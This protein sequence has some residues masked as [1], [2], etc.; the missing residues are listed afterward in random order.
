MF[1]PGSG[2]GNFARPPNPTQTTRR[3]ACPVATILSSNDMESGPENPSRRSLRRWGGLAALTLAATYGLVVLGGI[4]RITGSGLGC[5]PDWPLCQG[6][7][8]PPMDLPTLI[9]YGH[10]LAAASVVTLVTLL[11]VY[12]LWAARRTDVMRRPLRLSVVALALVLVQALL[13][14]VTVWLE[15]P[16]ATIVI[17]LGTAMLLL[18]LL[19]VGTTRALTGRRAPRWDRAARA[20][21]G[22]AGL[23]FVVVLLGALVAN[24]GASTACRGFPLCNGSL[25]PAGGWRTHLHWTHRLFAY[26]LAGL[27]VWLPFPVRRHRPGDRAAQRAVVIQIGIG[28][29]MVLGNLPAVLRALHVAGGAAV[30]ASLVWAAT[31]VSRP[32]AMAAASAEVNERQPAGGDADPVPAPA[33]MDAGAEGAVARCPMHAL[34]GGGEVGGARRAMLD[35]VALTKPRIISLL[36]VTTVVPM[37]VAGHPSAWLVVWTVVGGYLMAGGANAL[38]MYLDRDIDGTMRRTRRRPIPSGRLPAARVLLFGVALA[39][40]AFAVFALAAN[41][42][43]AVLALC[44][45][46]FYVFVYTRWLKRSTPQNIVIG[47]A[48]GAFPPLVGWAAV[49][50]HVGLPALFLFFIVFYW[51]PPHFWALALMKERDYADAR[52]PMAPVVWGERETK[53]QMLLYSLVLVPLSVMPVLTGALGLVYGCLAILLGGRFLWLMVDL[54]REREHTGRAWR[55]YRYSLLYLALLFGAMLVDQAVPVPVVERSVPT[56]ALRGA[57]PAAGPV[58]AAVRIVPVDLVRSSPGEPR[59]DPPAPR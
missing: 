46:L 58:S 42:L 8:I 19:V 20:T 38:N 3:G 32:R 33:T 56:V 31:L 10:R 9:E 40:V 24:L 21:A 48:A 36:L 55:L 47:G 30:F 28:A 54:I 51:T 16:P 49:S 22:L 44:G 2:A 43:A 45:L 29:G 37:F 50:G 27:A 25:V 53:R 7:L 23:A 5:G 1:A 11:V 4:V 18:A 6:R 39:A 41:L 34:E 13:G 35:Y 17:H 59:A 12:A 14:A 26:G 52:I 57:V 15:L